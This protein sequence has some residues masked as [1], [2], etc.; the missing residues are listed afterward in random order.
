MV[1]LLVF[2]RKR[3]ESQDQF[4]MQSITRIRGGDFDNFPEINILSESFQL[5]IE[6]P[7]I[8]TIPNFLGL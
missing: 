6:W 5:V 7:S 3:K 4:F 8:D 1:K 2:F